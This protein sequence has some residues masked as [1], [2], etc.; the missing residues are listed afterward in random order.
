M[1]PSPHN[2]AAD[3]C[4]GGMLG[5]LGRRWVITLT[6]GSLCA[7]QRAEHFPCIFS[8]L[9]RHL[10]SKS[11]ML[12]PHKPIFIC[13]KHEGVRK[14]PGVTQLMTCKAGIRTQVCQRPN[15]ALYCHSRATDWGLGH[16]NA[17]D[18]DLLENLYLIASPASTCNQSESCHHCL[19]DCRPGKVGSNARGQRWWIND[20]RMGL[21]SGDSIQKGPL[22]FSA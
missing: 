4:H 15:P 7:G 21:V 9:F 6:H 19:N 13:E 2:C 12:E 14:F 8:L 3:P 18:S 22:T 16:L 11:D 20:T 5:G 1:P 10:V 17:E